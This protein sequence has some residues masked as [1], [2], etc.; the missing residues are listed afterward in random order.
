MHS[1]EKRSEKEIS[2]ISY[3]V[4]ATHYI[5]S[6]VAGAMLFIPFQ[7]TQRPKESQEIRME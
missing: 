6:A 5:E 1:K 7:D 4:S 2:G 3:Q